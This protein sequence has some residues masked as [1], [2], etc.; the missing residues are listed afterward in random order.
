MQKKQLIVLQRPIDKRG[1]KVY[2]SVKT[3]DNIIAMYVIGIT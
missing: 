3:E 2:S 1:H